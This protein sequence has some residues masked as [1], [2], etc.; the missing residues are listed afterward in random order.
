MP[1]IRREIEIASRRAIAE[2]RQPF[3]QFPDPV[4]PVSQTNRFDSIVRAASVVWG[5]GAAFYGTRFECIWHRVVQE[6]HKRSSPDGVPNR[7][8]RPDFKIQPVRKVRLAINNA[9]S[10][11]IQRFGK[12]VLLTRYGVHS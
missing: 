7:F 5:S 12:Q 6:R 4:V 11:G 2:S 1:I 3:D 9:P 8:D 10:L